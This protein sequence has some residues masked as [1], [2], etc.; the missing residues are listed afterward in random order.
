MAKKLNQI[1]SGMPQVDEALNGW[2]SLLSFIKVS[3]VNVRGEITQTSEILSFNGTV[4]PLMPE[5][6]ET[7]PEGQRSFEWLQIHAF[8]EIDLKVNDRIDWESK[9]YK[10]MFKNNYKL[11]GY[12]EYHVI[13]DYQDA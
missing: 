10:V 2:T 11:N 3:Q 1:T 8:T 7:K 12:F 5:Q 4:Q 6:L 13:E 9:T